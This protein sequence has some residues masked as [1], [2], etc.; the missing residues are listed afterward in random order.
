MSNQPEINSKDQYIWRDER[1]HIRTRLKQIAKS[2]ACEYI[3]F[4][5]IKQTIKSTNNT[6]ILT[7]HFGDIMPGA[8]AWID[9]NEICRAHDK[10]LW[11]VTDNLVDRS[12]YNFDNVYIWSMP[13]L[14]GVSA[15]ID[16]QSGPLNSPSRLYNCFMQRCESVRQS[17]FYLLWLEGLLDKGYVSYL[18]YQLDDYSKLTGIDLFDFIHYTKGL[19][20]LEKFQTAYQELRT[21]VP[22]RNFEEKFDLMT[23]VND[24]KYSVVLETY[25]VEDDLD[26]WC[27]TEKVL[28]SLQSNSISLVFCQKHCVRELENLGLVFDPIN[29]EWD[30][31]DWIIRQRKILDVL[32]SDSVQFDV[33]IQRDRCDH[34]THVMSSWQKQYKKADFFDSMIEE[35]TS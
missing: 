13:Q 24:S 9:L 25:A 14:L 18:L 6:R 33:K 34:N 26:H 19:D 23:Y 30:G 27:V 20:Q 7:S 35:I 15:R 22:Y 21:N 29:H 4:K 1:Q 32:K 16:V 2:A 28:R 10:K 8:T 5:N 31:D 17:W 3:N 12:K 11:V